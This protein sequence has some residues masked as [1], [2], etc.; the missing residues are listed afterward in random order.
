MDTFLLFTTM[1]QLDAFE[2]FNMDFDFSGT[3]PLSAHQIIINECLRI[4]VQSVKRNSVCAEWRC[5]QLS[6]KVTQMP[7]HLVLWAQQQ[8]IR[9]A[10]Y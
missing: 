4:S 6:S 10:P 8:R 1:V 7:I 3:V 5:C 2:L 9:L